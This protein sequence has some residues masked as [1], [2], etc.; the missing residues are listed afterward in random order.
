MLRSSQ[1]SSCEYTSLRSEEASRVRGWILGNTKIGLVLDVKVCFHS[2]RYGIEVMIESLFRD[3][4]FLCS[5]CEW[6]QQIRNRNGRN[7]SLESVEHSV[8]GKLVAKARPQQ[9]LL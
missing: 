1:G 5:N 4:S 3:N 7:I 8:T 2:G 9:S 6:S